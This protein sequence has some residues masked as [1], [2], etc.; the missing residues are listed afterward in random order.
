MTE[1]ISG[2]H[3]LAWKWALLL[4]IER[5]RLI[6]ANDPFTMPNMSTARP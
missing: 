2:M 6:I 3:D 4:Q 1:Q 5:Y